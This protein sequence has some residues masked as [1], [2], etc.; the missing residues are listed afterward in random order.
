MNSTLMTPLT[1]EYH[2]C[3][4]ISQTVSIV[5][6]VESIDGLDFIYLLL[7]R[8]SLYFKN[9]TTERFAFIKGIFF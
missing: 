5:K 7:R 2:M 6:V 1:S 9:T 8:Y 3:I 4:T